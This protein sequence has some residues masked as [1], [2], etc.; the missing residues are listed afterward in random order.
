MCHQSVATGKKTGRRDITNKFGEFWKPAAGSLPQLPQH[1]RNHGNGHRAATLWPTDLVASPSFSNY[2]TFIYYTGNVDF[3]FFF[4]AYMDEHT[5]F[6][7]IFP[8]DQKVTAVIHTLHM[9]NISSSGLNKSLKFSHHFLAT[10]HFRQLRQRA[11]R[12]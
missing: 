5:V 7:F 11:H 9:A 12:H 2:L 10:I 8:S 6:S 3:Y 4:K 1:G